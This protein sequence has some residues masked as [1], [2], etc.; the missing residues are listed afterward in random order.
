MLIIIFSLPLTIL[1]L[2]FVIHWLDFLLVVSVLQCQ[3]LRSLVLTQTIELLALFTFPFAEITILEI[4]WQFLQ[5]LLL[6]PHSGL[7]LRA[8]HWLILGGCKIDLVSPWASLRKALDHTLQTTQYLWHISFHFHL[9]KDHLDYQA[10]QSCLWSLQCQRQLWLLN[11]LASITTL[12][13]PLSLPC[14]LLNHLSVEEVLHISSHLIF[15]FNLLVLGKP[16]VLVQIRSVQQSWLL[17]LISCMS[18]LLLSSSPWLKDLLGCWLGNNDQQL[19]NPLV[20]HHTHK[21]GKIFLG[22]MPQ[23]STQFL[24][25]S[26]Y[27]DS[28]IPDNVK[29]FCLEDFH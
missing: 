5:A 22:H 26:W 10:H 1:P 19:L 2:Q 9:V 4:P 28:L 17:R 21:K 14:H 12:W 18:Q 24:V 7:T 3:N 6:N 23:W 15:H 29:S 8:F 13:V 11:M 20:Y 16:W 25:L 27:I